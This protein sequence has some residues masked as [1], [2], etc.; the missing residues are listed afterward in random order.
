MALDERNPL[1]L[2][3]Q[4][5]SWTVELGLP[6]GF[7]VALLGSA[8]LGYLFFSLTWLSHRMEFEAD[9]YACQGCPEIQRE[10]TIDVDR[11]KDMSDALLRLASVTPS[12]FDR[13]TIMH[14]SIR[15]RIQLIREIQNS[16]EK[17]GQFRTAFVR[18]RRLVLILL[19]AICFLTQLV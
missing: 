17:A 4:L 8:Y 6:T 7:G 19:L 5:E 13:R 12:Q 9:I 11:S 14:P 1:G 2:I 3:N 10:K 18:R 16:P 15:E